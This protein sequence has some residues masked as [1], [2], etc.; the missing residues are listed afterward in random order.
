MCT[1]KIETI[2][3]RLNET[4]EIANTPLV[5]A[6]NYAS[7]KQ[8]VLQLELQSELHYLTQLIE[9]PLLFEERFKQRCQ[10]RF[11]HEK[12][13]I[14]F[15]QEP[16]SAT[17]SLYWNIAQI[18]FEP[19]S[20]Q[21]MLAILLPKV[22]KQLTVNLSEDYQG[23]Y[24]EAFNQGLKPIVN[25]QTLDSLQEKPDHAELAHFVLYEDLLLDTRDLAHFPLGSHCQFREQ[26]LNPT[27]P[28]RSNKPT[29]QL[30][31][32]LYQH[33]NDL[34]VLQEDMSIFE[35]KGITPKKALEQLIQGLLLGGER[36]TGSEMASTSA[37]EALARFMRYLKSLPEQVQH[38]L[39]QSKG[40]R[41]SLGDVIENE[42]EKGSCVETAAL[43][44]GE[45]TQACQ[46]NPLWNNP[47]AISTKGLKQLQDKYRKSTGLSTHKEEST[48]LELPEKYIEQ[49]F[50]DIEPKNH[51]EFI[52]L[53]VNIS[54]QWYGLLFKN[55]RLKDPNTALE[56][57]AQCIMQGMFTQDQQKALTEVVKSHYFPQ[58]SNANLFG[59]MEWAVLA[60]DLTLLEEAAE[61]IINYIQSFPQ[62]QRL[63]VITHG[64]RDETILHLAV[65]VPLFLKDILLSLSEEE[66]LSAALVKNRDEIKLIEAAA[67]S[68]IQSLRVFLE[69]LTEQ[70]RLEAILSKNAL[71]WNLLHK[72]ATQPDALKTI[73]EFLSKDQLA[74]VVNK[75]TIT[76][77]TVLTLVAQSP[78]LVKLI[79]Q[80]LPD[81]QRLEALTIVNRW[82]KS[83]L[84]YAASDPQLLLTILPQLPEMHRL[85]ALQLM[86]GNGNT[87]LHNA[88][89]SPLL[90]QG[91]L[92]YIPEDLRLEALQIK[93][94]NCDS[95]LFNARIHRESLK[96]IFGLLPI[97]ER[98]KAT[99]VANA[100]G[101]SLL[102]Y[103]ADQPSLLQSLLELLPEG[104]CLEALTFSDIYGEPVLHLIAKSPDALTEILKRVPEQQR[105]EVLQV[106]DKTKSTILDSA[107]NRSQILWSILPVLPKEERVELVLK[108]LNKDVVDQFLNIRQAINE[109]RSHGKRIS[110]PKGKVIQCLADELDELVNTFLERNITKTNLKD[111]FEEF[112]MKFMNKLHSNDNEMQKHRMIWKPIVANLLIALSG[113]GILLIGCKV[114]MQMIEK[115]PLTLNNSLFFAKTRSQELEEQVEQVLNGLIIN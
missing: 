114:A 46:N 26:L 79:L 115:K 36:M 58:N 39:K 20:M 9:E 94:Q 65:N 98:L 21:E 15:R 72:V 22:K 51:F 5:E 34:R 35:N 69:V 19:K 2:R 33:N 82:E 90:L 97:D 77:E 102:C 27:T 106:K 29:S 52:S 80:R 40:Q 14:G 23:K 101:R 1:E 66:R 32:P 88:L 91:I 13:H 67:Y 54:P 103:V 71:G 47:V 74:Q 6:H 48:Q 100:F 11:I 70:Q 49:A 96:I 92:E 68:D 28:V 113:V 17:N 18:Y 86:D 8:R 73:L 75:Q 112:Q 84:H 107:T 78:E 10:E 55:V 93:D 64:N 57:V 95:V 61:V 31:N 41:W 60:G 104:Q 30:L 76:G 85:H 89:N 110:E 50:Q 59:Y 56:L 105:I 42:L 3:K 12:E 24:K 83:V 53:I 38:D 63:E 87:A 43:H 81:N 16:L 4:S 111:G 37:E 108:Y 44:L 109:L 45:I 62:N 25:T 99:K 7:V